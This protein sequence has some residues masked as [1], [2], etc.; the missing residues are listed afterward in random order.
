[1]GALVAWIAASFSLTD[2]LRLRG[3]AFTRRRI[4]RLAGCK[5]L[6]KPLESFGQRLL[7]FRPQHHGSLCYDANQESYFVFGPKRGVSSAD[8]TF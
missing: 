3:L 8:K 5:I 2:Y 1:M 7:L 6:P 4:C